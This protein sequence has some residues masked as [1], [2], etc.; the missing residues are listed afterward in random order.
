MI[1]YDD[2]TEKADRCWT[3]RLLDRLEAANVSDDELD[4]L[5]GALQAVSDHRAFAVLQAVVVDAA[6]PARIRQ[7]AGSAL[8]GMQYVALDVPADKLRRWWQEGD[9][10]LRRH[11]LL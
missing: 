3:S 6:R 9:A 5:I 10:V 4:D 11:A 2:I 1:P 8:R 7:A